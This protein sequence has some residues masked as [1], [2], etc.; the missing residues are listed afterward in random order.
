MEIITA[1]GKRLWVRT[2]GEAVRDEG[3]NIYKVHGSFQD[4]SSR[5]Q[6]ELALKES[7]ELYR[8]MV[9]H[10]QQRGTSH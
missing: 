9:D 2:V 3:G 5:K 4:V 1:K 7:E 6:A 10:S 8:T